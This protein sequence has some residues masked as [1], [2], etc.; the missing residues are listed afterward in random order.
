MPEQHNPIP[1]EQDDAPFEETGCSSPPHDKL[2][3]LKKLIPKKNIS[4]K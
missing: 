3:V 1:N 4:R 2:V